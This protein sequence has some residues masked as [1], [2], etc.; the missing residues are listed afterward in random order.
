LLQFLFVVVRALAG[1][2]LFLI[3]ASLTLEWLF[4][5]NVVAFFDATLVMEHADV[6]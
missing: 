4:F 3:E 1:A 6:M 5:S 2:L